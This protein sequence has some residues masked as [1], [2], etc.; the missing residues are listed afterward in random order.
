[1][2]NQGLCDPPADLSYGHVSASSTE[3]DDED[4]SNYSKRSKKRKAHS[5]MQRTGFF[6]KH[7]ANTLNKVRH[8]VLNVNPKN[9][10][11]YVANDVSSL[12][13]V[14]ILHTVDVVEAGFGGG[15][16]AS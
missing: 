14:V 4:Y 2:K 11:S 10:T 6:S 8:C 5:N 12:M 3:S 7:E 13:G 9:C 16:G 15:E 1:M